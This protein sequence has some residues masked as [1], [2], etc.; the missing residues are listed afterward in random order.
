M[1]TFLKI[2]SMHLKKKKKNIH[3]VPMPMG[4][5]QGVCVGIL[6]TGCCPEGV[7]E[8]EQQQSKQVEDQGSSVARRLRP[9]HASTLGQTHKSGK[10]EV[11]EV[12]IPSGAP[13][14][15][16]QTL[17]LE[18]NLHM[19]EGGVKRYRC[20]CSTMHH[21]L[22]GHVS[23]GSAA[24]LQPA[25]MNITCTSARRGRRARPAGR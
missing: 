15:Q 7:V 4:I 8:S 11:Q 18:Q 16:G 25:C 3:V 12:E 20:R 1:L 10:V 22:L 9:V 14:R 6:G 23:L 13:W 17:Q 24:S 5:C 2:R 21:H 19:E